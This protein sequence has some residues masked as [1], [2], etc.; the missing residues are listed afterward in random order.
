M[1]NH[2][3]MDYSLLLITESNPD[4]IDDGSS[5]SDFKSMK[6]GNEFGRIDTVPLLKR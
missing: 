3:L 4:Y 6:S 5:A 1:A 2:N